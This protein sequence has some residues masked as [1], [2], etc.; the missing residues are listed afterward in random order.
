MADQFSSLR[1]Q[2]MCSLGGG[3]SRA[4]L[5]PASVRR[6]AVVVARAAATAGESPLALRALSASPA[7]PI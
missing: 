1:A 7:N 6:Q 3:R 4:T 5:Y 2:I